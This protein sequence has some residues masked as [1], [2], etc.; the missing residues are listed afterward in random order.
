MHDPNYYI[1]GKGKAHYL[2]STKK[3]AD[4]NP[5]ERPPRKRKGGDG[6]EGDDG[7]DDDDDGGGGAGSAPKRRRSTGARRGRGRGSYGDDDDDE[8]DAGDDWDLDNLDPERI[9]AEQARYQ[10]SRWKTTKRTRALLGEAADD[11][12]EASLRQSNPLPD[13]VDPIT[14]EPVVKPA[15]S[16]YGHVMRYAQRDGARVSD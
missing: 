6:E 2:F 4:G 13:H 15:I 14:L 9:Q 1:D 3:D 11:D 10:S 12:E 16:P 7:E 8:A 5:I